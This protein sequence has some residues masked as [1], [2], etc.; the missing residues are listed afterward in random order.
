MAPKTNTNSQVTVKEVGQERPG[1]LE[2]P[3]NPN[4][5]APWPKFSFEASDKDKNSDYKYMLVISYLLI[6]L[7]RSSQKAKLQG[8]SS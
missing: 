5:R 1:E 3:R 7:K 2:C 8:R 4:G 6:L